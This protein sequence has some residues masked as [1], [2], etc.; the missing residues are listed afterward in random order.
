MRM[1]CN[2]TYLLDQ[3]TDH[4]VKADELLDALG[5]ILEEPD[6]KV[7]IFSQWLRMHELV[8]RRVAKR[9]WDHVLFHGGVPSPRR[10]DLVHQFKD[11]PKCRLFL[12]TDAGGVGLN[13]QNASA[14][15]NLD[16]PWNPA[17][18]EQRVGRVHRLGQQRPVRVLH[19]IAQGTIEEG[20]LGLLAFKSAMFSGVL[21]DGQDEVFL[22][23]TRLKRFMESVEQATDSI[24]AAMP[25]Q[26]QSPAVEEP[27]DTVDV[28]QPA[29]G[30]QEQAWA[31]VLTTGMSLLEKLG[32]ALGTAGSAKKP[33]GPG[34]L[35]GGQAGLPGGII[36]RDEQTGQPY[37]KLPMPEPETIEKIV[38]L[39]G[40]LTKGR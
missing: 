37:L 12:S 25:P 27:A 24:P 18:I 30:P 38:D 16:Q 35:P 2:S 33:G 3:N 11:D 31:D 39:F 40:S 15:V 4:G 13:L 21:D 28:S 23:G 6:A 9:K 29:A 1:S 19:F 14:V 8:A 32:Q 22:G 34:G 10:K 26:T 17:V 5:D 20:M 36:S 7:V